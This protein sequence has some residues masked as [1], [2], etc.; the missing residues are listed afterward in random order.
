MYEPLVGIPETRKLP[1]S[2]LS[3]PAPS[4]SMIPSPELT[5]VKMAVPALSSVV[6]SSISM[7][8]RVPPKLSVAPLAIVSVP[9]PEIAI[10]QIPSHGSGDRNI[11]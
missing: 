1:P 5:L 3:I 9:N 10:S 6:P 7:E 4:S 11:H 2:W 8:P